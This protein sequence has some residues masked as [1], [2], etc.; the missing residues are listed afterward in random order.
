MYLR[1]KKRLGLTAIFALSILVSCRPSSE[2]LEIAVTTRDIEGIQR[3]LSS[4]VS[5]NTW[6]EDYDGSPIHLAS[7]RG[8]ADVVNLLILFG[9]EV[10]STSEKLGRPP[11]ELAVSAG[12]WD[13]ALALLE[14]GASPN[15]PRGENV[16]LNVVSNTLQNSSVPE[17]ALLR[18]RAAILEPF[19]TSD[20][21]L[22]MYVETQRNT[23]PF[24]QLAY[25]GSPIE[26][27][28]EFVRH[29]A[30][31]NM[32]GPFY[33]TPLMFAAIR[34][35]SEFAELLIESGA[36]VNDQTS[37]S[38]INPLL[39]AALV[40]S[41]ST[42]QVLLDGGADP[43]AEDKRGDTALHYAAVQGTHEILNLLLD[44]SVDPDT[45]GHR[46]LT[47]L[48]NAALFGQRK[49]VES[50]L[51]RGANPNELG[52]F[53]VSALYLAA[54]AGQAEIVEALLQG[55]ADPALESDAGKTPADI[56]HDKGYHELAN[57]LTRRLGR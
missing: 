13:T 16:R 4:G 7:E 43:L 22:G 35:D 37:M 34:G 50:L 47:A 54:G 14:A 5:A 46:D 24:W 10:A 18:E 42:A 28:R 44:A 29:G 55:G 17:N 3:I 2:S 8:F 25:R 30:E 52:E 56:A 19:L 53:N 27:A 31:C 23:T 36:K 1:M 12:S 49:I 9:A 20:Q 51:E 45:P 26:V 38:K 6:N 41:P 33:S 40:R 48:H 11:L 21:L 32:R 15:Q 57:L 39:L